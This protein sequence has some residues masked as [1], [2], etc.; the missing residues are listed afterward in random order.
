MPAHPALIANLFVCP[1]ESLTA[2][3]G[4]QNPA[5][6]RLKIF[7]YLHASTVVSPTLETEIREFRQRWEF[8]KEKEHRWPAHRKL[9]EE[10]E[11]SCWPFSKLKSPIC[12]PIRHTG[13]NTAA[14][15]GDLWARY[16][17]TDC[18]RIEIVLK[19]ISPLMSYSSTSYQR[20]Q[21]A[22]P[23]AGPSYVRMGVTELATWSFLVLWGGRVRVLCEGQEG[24]SCQRKNQCCVELP[25]GSLQR[26]GM[27]V[28]L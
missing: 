17:R 9:R 11:N 6:E 10:K 21:A 7:T 3:S 2:Q 8:D 16:G 20:V 24:V 28:L 14:V 4:A 12:Q 18:K 22:L 5:V 26:E 23:L 13:G 19:A 25:V 15:T 1:V 27:K